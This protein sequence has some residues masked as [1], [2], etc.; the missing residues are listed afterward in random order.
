MQEKMKTN[1]KNYLP[2]IVY[3]GSDGAV[4]TFSVMAG[5][6][7]A[8][9]PARIVIILGLANLFAD[10]FSM[11]SADYLSEDSKEDS[12]KIENLKSAFATFLSFVFIGAIPLIPFLYSL[13][14]T[15]NIN[16]FSVSILLTLSTFVLIGYLRGRVLRRNKIVTILQSVI[17]CSVSASVAYFVGEYISK[18]I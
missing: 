12:K 13:K 6:A 10:G 11:A 14:N 18:L 2:S 1:I 8:G 4:T 7:G 5:A 15:G 17:I 16:V 9:L 3:G